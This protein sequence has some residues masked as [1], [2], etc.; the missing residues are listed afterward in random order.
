MTR[1]WDGERGH[2]ARKTLQRRVRQIHPAQ[3][4]TGADGMAVAQA[5]LL[6]FS[7]RSGPG[8]IV[9]CEWSLS[10]AHTAVVDANQ[11]ISNGTALKTGDEL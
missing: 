1:D 5:R 2:F 11:K 3:L 6:E 10:P 7:L 8:K 4:L 9:W